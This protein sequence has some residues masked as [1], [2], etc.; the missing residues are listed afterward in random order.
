MRWAA[1]DG[2]VGR[3]LGDGRLWRRCWWRGGRLCRVRRRGRRE[4]LFGRG[5]ESCTAIGWGLVD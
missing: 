4:S 1:A 2:G 5:C 3:G